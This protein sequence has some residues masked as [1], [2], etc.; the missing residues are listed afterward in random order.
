MP[1]QPAS[2]AITAIAAKRPNIACSLKV[3]PAP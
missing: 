1:A 3:R 2:V